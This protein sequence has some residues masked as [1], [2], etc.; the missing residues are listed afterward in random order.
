[1][2]HRRDA[3]LRLGGFGLGALTLPG[4]LR[5][6]QAQAALADSRRSGGKA[7]SCILVYLWGGPPQLDTFD[8][9]PDAPEGI[10][11]PFQPIDT[12]VPGI[13]ISDQL[14]QIARHTDKMALIRSMK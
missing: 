2:L 5:A 11:S 4:L 1:M 12:V 9:K 7:K 13:Q 3:M 10:R 6:E 14:P 8:L